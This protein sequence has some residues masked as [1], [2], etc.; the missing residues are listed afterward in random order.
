MLELLGAPCS[1]STRGFLFSSLRLTMA[2]SFSRCLMNSK[3]ILHIHQVGS[4]T[5]RLTQP[6]SGPEP[7][8]GCKEGRIQAAGVTSLCASSQTTE[9]QPEV[10]H[11]LAVHLLLQD[12]CAWTERCTADRR[13]TACRA[14]CSHPSTSYTRIGIHLS[15]PSIYPSTCLHIISI[16]YIYIYKYK[17]AKPGLP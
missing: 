5:F 1:A 6:T 11:A 16:I 2:L 10:S 4:L 15:Y 14:L 8:L 7:L 12:E 3:N 9:Y 13:S 17:Y